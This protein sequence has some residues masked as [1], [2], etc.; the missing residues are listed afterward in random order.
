MTMTQVDLLLTAEQIW[1][2]LAEK[3]PQQFSQ[4][5]V[6]LLEIYCVVK[7]GGAAAQ[8]ATVQRLAQAERSAL[9]TEIQQASAQPY[10]DGRVRALQQELQELDTAMAARL[11]HLSMV[12]PADERLVQQ[13]LF[14]IEAWMGA[15]GAARHAGE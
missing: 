14:A 5:A 6:R 3:E 9:L 8:I 1:G 4:D 7:A 10:D 15:L 13:H 2:V 11:Q 12:T